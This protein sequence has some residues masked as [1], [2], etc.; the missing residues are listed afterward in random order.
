M[1]STRRTWLAAALGLVGLSFSPALLAAEDSRVFE[2]RTYVTHP[3]KLPNLLTRFRDH[4]CKLFEKHGMKNIGYWVPT[5]PAKGADNTLIYVIAHKS[6][7]AAKAS[8]AAFVA[9]PDWQAAAKASE[10]GGKI[11]AAKPGA[12]F[13]T[14]TDYSCAIKTGIEDP[15]RVFELRTYTT[16]EGK[17]P[18]LHSR[19]RDHTVG[20]FSKH[21]MSHI[22]YW[23]P[24]DAEQGASTKLIYIL[25]HKSEAAAKASFGAF[26]EDPAW[27]TAKAASEKEGSLTVQPHGVESI[28]LK[29]TDFS[30]IK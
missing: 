25:S 22:G 21:G 7:D 29:P 20:L 11:L 16:P 4:T 28:F 12:V 9:D 30:L 19:F 2:L 23:T 24:T 26:R 13:M 18:A 17:L 5:D 8:W 10:A 1:N 6:R 14:T 15:E 27:I 3:G